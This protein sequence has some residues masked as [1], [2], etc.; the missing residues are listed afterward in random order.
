MLGNSEDRISRAATIVTF[1]LHS[2]GR[3]NQI[4]LVINLIK[5]RNITNVPQ[6]IKQH[7]D[8]FKFKLSPLRL[9]Y[10]GGIGN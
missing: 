5:C 3:F 1:W 6:V 9:F 2:K 8:V 7:S 4:N 10:T